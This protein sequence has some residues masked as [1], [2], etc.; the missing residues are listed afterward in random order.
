MNPNPPVFGCV[1]CVSD[2]RRRDRLQ[3]SELRI[4]LISQQITFLKDRRIIFYGDV[5]VT[6]FHPQTLS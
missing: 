2:K 6:R 3:T 4:S 1:N 5:V